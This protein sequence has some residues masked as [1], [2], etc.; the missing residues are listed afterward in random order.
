MTFIP[1]VQGSHH[2]SQDGEKKDPGEITLTEI[3]ARI[4]ECFH[5]NQAIINDE[6]VDFFQKILRRCAW[7][8]KTDEQ[9]TPTVKNA[10]KC[11]AEGESQGRLFNHLM[12][13]VNGES[14]ALPFFN[15]Q[16]NSGGSI[17]KEKIKDFTFG[18]D[19]SFVAGIEYPDNEIKNYV[20][21][22]LQN[23]SAIAG[24]YFDHP[25]PLLKYLHQT[26]YKQLSLVVQTALKVGGSHAS[27]FI[28]ALISDE[29]KLSYL[30]L[31]VSHSQFP[32]SRSSLVASEESIPDFEYEG[33]RY[34]VKG[35]CGDGACALH[36]LLGEEIDGEYLFQGAGIHSGSFARRT[37]TDRLEKKLAE[38]DE[39]VEAKF[40]AVI[41][42]SLANAERDDS[43]KMLCAGGSFLKEWQSIQSS[44][45][46]DLDQVKQEEATIWLSLAQL[47]DSSVLTQI[48]NKVKDAA[49]QGRPDA[50]LNGKKR[51]QI[52]K[53]LHVNPKLIPHIPAICN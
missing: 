36:A 25:S 33:R 27:E 2:H 12:E 17:P 53:V 16:V 26:R 19:R 51:A 4:L 35:T 37:F 1:T 15:E 28:K 20:E 52:L 49:K 32:G 30:N 34:T 13:W 48:V 5:K 45:K 40:I 24:R 9:I 14:G 43:A 6:F 46:K 38:S 50:N 29:M 41:K 44:H 18:A 21:N 23:R 8:I 11:F 39:V 7:S 10:L 22:L 42:S 31:T 47:K 3:Q